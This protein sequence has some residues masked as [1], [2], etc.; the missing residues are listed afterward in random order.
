MSAGG[1]IVLTVSVKA[2]GAIDRTVLWSAEPAQGTLVGIDASSVRYVAPMVGSNT[3]ITVKARSKANPQVSASA[4]LT[5][6]PVSNPAPTITGITPSA[7]GVG[8]PG[9]SLTVNGSNFMA[10]SALRLDGSNRTTTFVSSNQLTAQIL[11]SDV[12]SV[13]QGQITVVNP[14]PGGGTSNAVELSIAPPNPVP[15]ISSIS[16]TTALA[17]S[18]DF[19]LT[20]NGT[21]FLPSSVIQWNGNN[22]GTAFINSA[23]LTAQIS[24][25]DIEVA[26]K[27][28]VKVFNPAPGGGLSNGLEFSV[29]S[30][31]PLPTISTVSPTYSVSQYYPPQ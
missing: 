19:T 28:Q 3:T 20:V 1:N 31:N 21:H 25:S 9:F 13:G 4:T 14:A 15:S 27:A 2:T 26:G 23:Q 29:T 5:I 11:A 17:G 8:S 24:A 30:T 10:G 6:T 18:T 16:P 12:A 22:K 7:V